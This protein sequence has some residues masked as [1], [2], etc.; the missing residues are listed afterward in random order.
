MGLHAKNKTDKALETDGIWKDY[1]THRV[2]IARAGGSNDR[3][4]KTMED[5]QKTLRRSGDPSEIPKSRQDAIMAKVLAETIVLDWQTWDDEK[6]DW[7]PGIEKVDGSVG[8]FTKELVTE[9]LLELPDVMNVI[10][11]DAM[12]HKNFLE[13]VREEEKGN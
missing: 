9:T 8:K 4:L 6:Q 3:Y 13:T 2:K 12:S 5:L 10:Q 7:V 1:I 11:M